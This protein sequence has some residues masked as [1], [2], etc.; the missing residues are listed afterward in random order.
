MPHRSPALGKQVAVYSLR[1][2]GFARHGARPSGACGARGRKGVQGD[3]KEVLRT[4]AKACLD[5]TLEPDIFNSLP[6]QRVVDADQRN[7]R[8]L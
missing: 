2:L 5:D 7:G 1:H 4:F 6:G 3:T 8:L